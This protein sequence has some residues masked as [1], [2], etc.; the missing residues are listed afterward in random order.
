MKDRVIRKV[1]KA[2]QNKK[3]LAEMQAQARMSAAFAIPQISEAHAK[4]VQLSFAALKSGDTTQNAN[5]DA[6]LLQYHKELKNYGFDERDFTYTPFCPICGDTGNH[7]GKVC[8]CV[9]QEYISAL[10]EE[11]GIQN[12]AHFTFADFNDFAIKSEEQ[13]KILTKLYATMRTYVNKFPNVNKLNVI[14]SGG[15]GTGKTCL[16][17]AMANAFINKGNSVLFLSAY[18]FNALMLK[19]HTSPISERN[20]ILHDLLV[21]DVLVIDD[22]GTEPILKNVT[23]EYLLLTL[24]ERLNHKHCTIITSNLNSERILDHYNERIYSRLSDKAHSLFFEING[25]DLRNTKY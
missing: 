18:E 19:C 21:A 2:R 12:K 25:Q 6:A 11:C 10:K 4:Y 13:K 17:S 7:N 14:F 16:A 24:E 22:L 23:N 1:L 9:W 15:V 8:K 5:I 3:T 20:S